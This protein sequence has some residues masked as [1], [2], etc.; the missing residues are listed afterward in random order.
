VSLDDELR[1]V[2][3][4]SLGRLDP[5][6]REGLRE[7]IERLR[8][9]QLA[10]HGPA[11][12]DTLPDFAL[13][14]AAGRVVT[15]GELLDRGPLVLAFFRGGWCPYCD[16]TLRALEA[17]RPRLEEAGATLAGV[18]PARPEE[19]ARVAAERGLR[20][21]LLSDTGGRLAELCGL[22]YAMTPAQIAFYRDRWGAD[23]PAV[24]AGTGWELPLAATYVAD[25]DGVIAY[26]F[27]DADWARRAEPR[28]LLDAVLA[29][30]ARQAAGA[31]T[32][33][34]A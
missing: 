31:V 19:L 33:D 14:D 16:R 13:P 22:L 18:A 25:R 11:V 30:G 34:G 21:L 7:A 26:A 4:A 6:E 10:E 32:A 5:A 2:R 29:L 24:G 17:V 15:S 1:S 8:M 3:A 20:F 9:R 27:A 12:G 28:D 23:L